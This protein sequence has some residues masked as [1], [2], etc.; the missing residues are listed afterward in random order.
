MA[1]ISRGN[2]KVKGFKDPEMDFQLIRQLGSVAYGAAS[3]G[4]VLA[5]ADKIKDGD[6]IS[7][8][9]S[10]ALLGKLQMTEAEKKAAAGHT[11]SAH[12]QFLKACNSF[13]AAEY[14][15]SCRSRE[16]VELGLKSRSSFLEAMKYVDHCFRVD[17]IDYNNIK[18]PLYF[19]QPDKQ[20]KKRKTILIVSGFDGTMEE[21]YFMRGYAALKRGYNIVHFAGPGQMDTFR[22]YPDTYFEPDFENVVKAV[23][24]FISDF[25]SVDMERLA[26]LGI[27]FGGYFATRAA[28]REPRIKALIANSPILSLYDYIMAFADVGPKPLADEEDFTIEDL[29]NIPDEQM[30]SGFRSMVENLMIRFGHNS[31]KS[32]LNYLKEFV[33]GDDIKN[34]QCPCLSM[35]G[36]DEGEEPQKQSEEFCNKVRGKVTS[37]KFSDIEG[38]STHCQVGNVSFANSVYL[39]WLDEQFR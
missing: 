18:I 38:A 12:G 31:F 37:Y 26:L 24:N 32:T 29:K 7:W 9:E 25:N 36:L 10:F 6:P 14:Y 13:R 17:E 15:T 1:K 35:I 22:F 5:I 11:I 8:V 30:P 23:I 34:I 27:S 2:I 16:H 20:I 33:V 4:E 28:S 3:V 39:D 19:M 21:E